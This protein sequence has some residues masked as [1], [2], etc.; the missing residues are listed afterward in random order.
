[1]SVTALVEV[2]EWLVALLLADAA[3]MALLGT[4]GAE[5]TG[6]YDEAAPE[7]APFDYIVIGGTAEDDGPKWIGSGGLDGGEDVRI[8]TRPLAGERPGA[9]KAKGIYREVHRLL[10]RRTEVGIANGLVLRRPRLA[11]ITSVLEQDRVT[12][13]LPCRFTFNIANP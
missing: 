13:G 5:F 3:L 8:F 4:D 7:G 12:T 6:V 10:H 9:A 11:L 2:R 1:M